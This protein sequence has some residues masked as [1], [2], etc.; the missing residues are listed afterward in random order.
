MAQLTEQNVLDYRRGGDTIADFAEKYMAEMTRIYQFL[1]NIRTHN[2]TG[3]VQVEPEPYQLKVEDNK[4]YIRNEGNDEWVF[5]MKVAK[6]G[7]FKADTFGKLT[8]GAASDKPETGVSTYDTYWDTDNGKVYMYLDDAWHLLL[9]L[10]VADLTGYNNLVKR[11][12]DVIEPSDTTTVYT[13]PQKI[14]QTNDNGVLPVD[15]LGNAGKIAGIKNEVNNLQ[16]GQVLT[17]R[18]VSNS[19]R[20]EPK[21]VVGAGASLIINDGETQLAEYSGD[22]QKIVDIGLS[23]HKASTMAHADLLHLRKPETAYAVGDI[24]YSVLLPSWAYLECTVGGTTDSGDLTVPSS[25][26]VNDTFTDGTVIWKIRKVGGSNVPVGAIIQYAVNGSLPEGFLAC[27]GGAVSRTLYAD[28]FGA[29]GTT[30]GVGDGNT[31]FNLP[32]YTGG[33]FPEG[34]TTA[35]TSHSA[36]LP[37]IKGSWTP[38]PNGALAINPDGVFDG[39]FTQ[40][41]I[42]SSYRLA[43]TTGG[44]MAKLIFNASLSSSIYSDSVTTVQPKSLTTRFIIKYQ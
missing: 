28:L 39:A 24:A 14:V 10:N 8:S 42:I 26:V 33:T 35:G 43:G 40:E 2:S 27:D 25:V 31:T 7:G 44:N 36:G 38:E 13:T 19:W 34:S 6:N 41:A 15:I 16:D 3:A 5:L 22:E 32:N 30:Y 37:N 12:T 23:A 4:I 29:I 20:N 9:S 11:D 21:G 1:N 17:Y 18:A